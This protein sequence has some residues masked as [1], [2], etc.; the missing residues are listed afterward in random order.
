[1][2][3]LSE[4]PRP[5]RVD[6]LSAAGREILARVGEH[7]WAIDLYL[8][9]S[10]ALALYLGHRPVRDLDLMGV[11]RLAS[12]ERRDLL[13]DLL[14]FEPELRVETARDGFLALRFPQ[15]RASVGLRLYYFPYP[16]I[17]PEQEAC[18][19]TVASLLDLAAMKLAAVAS[20]ATRRD[21]FDLHRITRVLPLEEILERSPEKFGHVRDFPL[22]A[23]Q[24]LADLDS[25]PEEPLPTQAESGNSAAAWR[26]IEAWIEGEVRDVARRR[27]ELDGE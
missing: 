5:T 7:G 4:R 27:L 10:A 1:M 11:R 24:A 22:R 9:G 26:E 13:Q 18:G 12:P 3:A 19:I 20:R 17:D 23:L 2:A 14:D 25:I 8:A 16:L 21:L 15:S 6:S